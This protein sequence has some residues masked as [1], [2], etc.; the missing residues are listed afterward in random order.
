MTEDKQPRFFY[1]YVIV[2]ASFPVIAIM[3]GTMYSFGVFFE[4]ILTEFGWPRATTSI[5]YSLA[6][7][8]GGLLSIGT[9]KLNDRFGP[10]LVMTGC[11]ISLGLGYLLMSQVSSLWQLYLLYGALIGIG[12]SGA[13]VPLLSTIAHWFVRRRGMVTGITVSGLSLG[14]MIIPPIVSQLIAAYGWRTAYVVTGIIALLLIVSAS[15]LLKRDP[16]QIGQLAYGEE[17]VALENSK[18]EIKGFSLQEAIHTQQLWMLYIMYFS[19]LFCVGTIA[20]HMVIHATGLGLSR[21]GAASI[22]TVYGGGSIFGR[23][24]VGTASDKIGTRR[25][26]TTSLILM[27]A[28]LLWLTTAQ[29]A[30]MLYPIAAIF[31]FGYGGFTALMSLMPAELFGLRSLGVILGFILFGAEIGEAIGPVLAGHIF[32]ITNSYQMAFL[33]STAV[34]LTGTIMTLLVKPI[35]QEDLISNVK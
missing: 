22:L 7:L 20:V 1:G 15:Q 2:L 31:G 30:W 29:D 10:R 25:A 18:L 28:A 14:I 32:D 5:A 26:S 35:H 6:M 8:M 17:K 27:S 21:T 16:S 24:T 34:A 13:W 33:I 19:F 9:G 3:W 23:L 4:S 12:M 11:G